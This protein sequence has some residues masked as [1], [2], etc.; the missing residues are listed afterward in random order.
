MDRPSP[1]IGYARFHST[2]DIAA[3][4][5]I[6]EPGRWYPVLNRMTEG[7]ELVSG[8]GL[9]WLDMGLMRGVPAEDVEFREG[10]MPEDEASRP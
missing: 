5:P 4:Y 1:V 6:H 7:H 10:E 3:R 2:P 8:A 9:L